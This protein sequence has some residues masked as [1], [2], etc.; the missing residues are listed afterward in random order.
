ML[1][2]VDLTLLVSENLIQFSL[3][4]MELRANHLFFLM[5]LND[6]F[7][8]SATFGARLYEVFFVIV[9]LFMGPVSIYH[10]CN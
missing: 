7:T 9:Q 2:N 8:S 10:D 4:L 6:N 3:H 1:V 5:L